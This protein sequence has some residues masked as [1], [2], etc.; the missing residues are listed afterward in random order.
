VLEL[1]GGTVYA[2]DLSNNGTWINGNR[3]KRE[4]R[5]P[6]KNGGLDGV[7][8]LSDPLSDT[9]TGCHSNREQPQARTLNVVAPANPPQRNP[10]PVLPTNDQTLKIPRRSFSIL[11]IWVLF[12]AVLVVALMIY[13]SLLVP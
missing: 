9:T 11:D 12:L 8:G 2:T 13:Y 6:L 10:K 1:V 3:L 7:A 5:A 4:Q